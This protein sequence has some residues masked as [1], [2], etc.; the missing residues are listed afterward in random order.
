MGLGFSFLILTC[1]RNYISVT[2]VTSFISSYDIPRIIIEYSSIHISCLSC[3]LKEV[4]TFSPTSPFLGDRAIMSLA[5]DSL[6]IF[7]VAELTT[8]S[9]DLFTFSVAFWSS[10]SSPLEVLN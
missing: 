1:G 9:P 5:I 8:V 7:I 2:R 6:T 10:D 3:W 4:P